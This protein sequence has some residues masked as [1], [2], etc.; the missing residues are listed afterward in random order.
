MRLLPIKDPDRSWRSIKAQWRKDAESVGEEFATFGITAFDVLATKDGD[1]PGLYCLT[2]GERT[3]AVCQVRRLLMSKYPEPILCARYVNVSPA[4]ELGL[5]GLTGYSQIL[6]ALFSG[7]V[8]LSRHALSASHIRFFLKSPGDSQFFAALQ[9]DTPLSP[10]AKFA[11]E[12]ALI[13]CSV[14]EAGIPHTAA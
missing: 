9:A 1:S 10:F 13:E 3:L 6:V 2:D 4:C 11:I 14:R 7:V 8:W 12:G 5:P